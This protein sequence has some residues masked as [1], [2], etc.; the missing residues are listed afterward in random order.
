LEALVD[1][2]KV[3]GRWPDLEFLLDLAENDPEPAVRYQLIRML[4]DNPP[5]ERAHKH[6]LDK[7]ELAERL[8]NLV[9]LVTQ[10]AK[11]GVSFINGQLVLFQ[12]DYISQK[13]VQKNVVLRNC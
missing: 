11:R 2:T 7:E 10:Y 4:V 9:K 1:F 12:S 13:L 8:W 5:F 3:D 6:R